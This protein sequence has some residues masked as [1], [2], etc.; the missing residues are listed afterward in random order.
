MEIDFKKIAE[1]YN[2]LLETNKDRLKTVLEELPVG[3]EKG[4]VLPYYDTLERR[5]STICVVG[6]KWQ[7]ETPEAHS[8]VMLHIV[9]RDETECD[10]YNSLSEFCFDFRAMK[11]LWENVVW[12]KHTEMP[13]VIWKLR[14]V[15]HDTKA[16]IHEVEERYFRNRKDADDHYAEFT[17]YELNNI[18]RDA[19]SITETVT[20]N[21]CTFD[22]KVVGDEENA[23][24]FGSYEKI[25]VH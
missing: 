9:K 5:M 6:I 23:Y 1:V 12:Y 4:L 24:S 21:K 16:E 13:L 8:N 20:P 18:N 14:L 11:N 7:S 2:E 15:R 22:A 25:E 3:G 10:V 17:N 19:W